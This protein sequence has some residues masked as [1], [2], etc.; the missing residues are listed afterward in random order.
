MG[1]QNQNQKEKQEIVQYP[2]PRPEEIL[3]LHLSQTLQKRHKKIIT[4]KK[5]RNPKKQTHFL[6]THS[7]KLLNQ[8]LS[9]QMNGRRF[10][11]IIMIHSQNCTTWQTNHSLET[12]KSTEEK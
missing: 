3:N 11:M 6:Q 12:G 2:N 5:T 10:Q 1:S 7:K 8:S 9:T 4:T